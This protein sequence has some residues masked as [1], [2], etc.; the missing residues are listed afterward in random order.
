MSLYLKAEEL[1]TANT[2]EDNVT[3]LKDN[4]LFNAMEDGITPKSKI[5]ALNAS[6]QFLALM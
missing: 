1:P 4:E 5:S 3:E 2:V 6:S